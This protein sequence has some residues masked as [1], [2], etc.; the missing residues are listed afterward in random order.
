MIRGVMARASILD[1]QTR[2]VACMHMIM[3]YLSKEG[4]VRRVPRPT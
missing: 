3:I 4:G 1:Y 2:I